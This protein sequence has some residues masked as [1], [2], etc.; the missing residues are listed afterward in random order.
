MTAEPPARQRS[1]WRP[2]RSFVRREGRITEAQRRA[3]ATLSA[4]YEAPSG[5]EILDLPAL[6]GREAE[7]YLEIGCGAGETLAALA[8]RHPENDYLGVE[9]YRPGLGRLLRGL[10]GAGLANVRVLAEDAAEVFSR[11]I[12]DRCLSGVY[13]FFPDPWP[14]ARHRK[15]RLIQARFAGCLHRTLLPH[16]RV[17]LA[18]DCEDYAEHILSVM[19]VEHGFVNLAGPA[20]FAPRPAWRPMT[21]Y[22]ERARRCG[23]T[24]RD[25]VFALA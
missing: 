2:L 14:K 5:T 1:E 23:H 16:A 9:V 24:V 3:L 4:R 13:L 21:R 15:R 18:T 20:R 8:A 22:E 10:A 12:P 17:F 6:F 7:R 25:M 19:S 11:R